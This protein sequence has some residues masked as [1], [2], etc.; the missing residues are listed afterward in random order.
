MGFYE[1]Q[2]PP[3]RIQRFLCFHC[4]RSFSSQTFDPTYWL[5]RPE[6]L[7]PLLFR[8]LAC[9]A[10]RQIAREFGVSPTT[11]A[12]QVARLGRHC[13]LFQERY[14]PARELT[15]PLVIDGF[16]SFEFS[17]YWP[18]H[19]NT[20]VGA[21]SHFLYAFTDSELR[22]KGRMSAVQRKRRAE[23]EARYGRP[24][25][26]A[27]EKGVAELL[28]LVARAPAALRVHSDDHPAYPRAFQRLPHLEITHQVTPSR[29]ARNPQ[30]PLFAVNVLDLLLRHSGANHKR[31]TIAFSKRRQSAVERMAI[32]QVWRNFMKS[33]SERKRDPTPAERL[34]I[35]RRKLGIGDVLRSR[36]FAS[37]LRLP[38]RV[39]AYY[40]REVETRQLPRNN[41]HRLQYAF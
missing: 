13:L 41:R 12:R 17:Q 21:R 31:E 16:E 38:G 37:R 35:V 5:K 8:T 18:I 29:R 6:L 11:V 10:Y 19:L 15:E 25:P 23:L 26:R 24:D 4:R 36:L 22:R 28:R 7:K 32:L 20:A 3:H 40:G 34:G 1:R 39:R 27:I 33:V 30:N 9:S 14:R 2:I